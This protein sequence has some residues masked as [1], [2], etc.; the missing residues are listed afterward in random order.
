MAGSAGLKAGAIGFVVGLVLAGLG[1]IQLPFVGCVC[2][3]TTLLAY[4]GVGALAGYF[5][6]RPR[7]AGTGAGAGALAGALSG[8]GSTIVYGIMGALG[9]ASSVGDISS[10]LDP[11]TAQ[12][13]ADAG[14]DPQAFATA[15]GVGG[16]A[17]MVGICCITLVAL[18]AMLGALGGALFCSTQTE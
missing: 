1:R 6:E 4:A 12:Q 2:C 11:E 5:T 13:L 8:I 3:L 17:M 10:Y 9:G 15:S 7:S 14:L 16:I 18:G